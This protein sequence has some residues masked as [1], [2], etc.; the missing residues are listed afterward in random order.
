MNIKKWIKKVEKEIDTLRKAK[1]KDRL[2]YTESINKCNTS[3]T[4]SCIGWDEWL[5]HP[6]IMN[7]FTEDE[8]DEMHK[9]FQ[10]IAVRFL[11]FDIKWTKVLTQKFGITDTEELGVG[12]EIDENTTYVSTPSDDDR[13]YIS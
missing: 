5:K 2:D 1:P 8:L 3:I 4:A 7:S 10:Y 13:S 11:D 9:E 6:G 12:E